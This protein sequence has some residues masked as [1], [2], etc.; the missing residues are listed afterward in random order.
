[1]SLRALRLQTEEKNRSKVKSPKGGTVL[2]AIIGVKKGKNALRDVTKDYIYS[3]P[4]SSI[5]PRPRKDIGKDY[6]FYLKDTRKIHQLLAVKS[7]PAAG[8]ASHDKGK[9]ARSN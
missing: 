8:N 9:K 4:Y 6:R 1:M 2:R 7:I 3:S 5:L